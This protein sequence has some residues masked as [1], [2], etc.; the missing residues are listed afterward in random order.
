[1]PLWAIGF[2][3]RMVRLETKLDRYNEVLDTAR[4]A[5]EMA[6][7]HERELKAL[8]EDADAGRR[9]ESL[10]ISNAENIKRIEESIRK[11][12]WLVLGA[13]ILAILNL[14]ITGTVTP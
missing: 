13:V 4:E 1:M 12:V 8:R 5:K 3:E 6:E 7:D 9:A 10:A 14:V 2:L 11:G